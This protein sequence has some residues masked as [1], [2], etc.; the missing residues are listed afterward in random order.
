MSVK[1][2]YG[3][4]QSALAELKT[5]VFV[6]LEEAG[7]AG[8][9][10]VDIGKRLGIHCGPEGRRGHLSRAVLEILS[11]D[12]TI[13]QLDNKRWAVNCMPEEEEDDD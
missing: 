13:R 1:K 4:A 8:L 2:A 3:M 11:N 10:N 12:G 6:L 5:A 7:G 9:R